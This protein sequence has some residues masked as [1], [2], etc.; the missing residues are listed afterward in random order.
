MDIRDEIIEL[1]NADGEVVKFAFV[2]TVEH[3]GDYYVALES[4]EQK[5]GIEIA[6]SKGIKFGRKPIERP[7]NWDDA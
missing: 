2:E 6:K 7:Y 5:E 4:T 3:E 1:E